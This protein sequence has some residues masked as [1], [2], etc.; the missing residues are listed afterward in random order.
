MTGPDPHPEPPSGFSNLDLPFLSVD[1]DPRNLW[2]RLYQCD[3]TSSLYFGQGRR[4]RFDDPTGGYS[5]LYAGKDIQCAF[6]ETF[7]DARGADGELQIARGDIAK[8]CVALI[9]IVRPLRVVDLTGSGLSNIRAD[10]RLT[11]GDDY[12]LSQ[13]WGRELFDH[14]QRPDGVLYRARHD[15]SRLSLALFN[16]ASDAVSETLLGSLFDARNQSLLADI[17][18][19]YKIALLP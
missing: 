2:P 5:V 15:Q 19:T 4:Y 6:I 16:R 3:R 9:G 7:G 10:A 18:R 11:A 1:P 14:S 12:G 17:L 13:R 8:R